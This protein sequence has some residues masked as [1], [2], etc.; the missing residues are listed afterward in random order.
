MHSAFYF[1]RIR[2]GGAQLSRALNFSYG[3]RSAKQGERPFA[4]TRAMTTRNA[5][6]LVAEHIWAKLESEIAPGKFGYV[7]VRELWS[8]TEERH[9]RPGHGWLFE[10]GDAGNGSSIEKT[11]K[12]ARASS[13]RASWEVY[14]GV[15]F[16]D[17][18]K[19]RVGP[20]SE[21]MCTR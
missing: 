18:E 15:R 17:G 21:K 8:T 4:A 1:D 14:K 2:R 11:F 3:K 5:F 10:F 19:V 7:Q 9:Y 12:L 13:S 16:Y 6:D 20:A